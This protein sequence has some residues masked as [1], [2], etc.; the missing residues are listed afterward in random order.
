MITIK[1]MADYECCP[2][3]RVG[4]EY[5]DEVDPDDLPLSPEL[6]DRLMDWARLY[7]DTL[8]RDSPRD[9]GFKTAELEAAFVAEG[10]DLAV[11]LAEEL[12]PDYAVT[13]FF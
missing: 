7:D 9:S 8:D 2:L 3:W 5:H 11:C 10:N 1:L 12:G 4:D 6:R 13:K